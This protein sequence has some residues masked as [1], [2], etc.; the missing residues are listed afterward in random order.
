MS[1]SLT[2][3][4]EV[5]LGAGLKVS[6]E[7]G[8]RTRGIGDVATIRGVMLHHTA[9][10]RKQDNAPSLRLIVN[11]RAA[12]PGAPALSGPLAQLVLGRD[13][14][15]Y[16]VAAGKANH[17]GPGNWRGV[18]SGNSS[19]IGI[20]AEN[21]GLPDDPWPAVQMDAYRRG[22][23]AILKYIK[24]D[25]NWC[26]G[27]KEYRLPPGYKVDPSFDMVEFRT[28][29]AAILSGTVPAPV[30]IPANNGARPT[31]RRGMPKDPNVAT[32]QTKLGIGAGGR[33]G[34]GTEAAVRAFQRAHNVV[35]DG[36]VGPKTW[37]LIDA[38]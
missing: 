31:L 38:G 29:V 23:A 26:C 4:P 24:A 27:H 17:A 28:G 9:S 25:A 14:T 22:V 2:W 21:S 15:Y 33:F 30:L 16:V 6:E 20:E 3:L 18:Q 32:L 35:A 11:G 13:G 19:F 8:W 12:S 1:Y 7:L 36:I 5:L 34:A 37:A 10:A